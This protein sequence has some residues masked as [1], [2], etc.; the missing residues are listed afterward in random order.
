M[1]RR[2]LAVLALLILVL[3]ATSLFIGSGA[4][5]RTPS[6]AGPVIER[7]EVAAPERATEWPE[8]EVEALLRN[9][10]NW[11]AARLMREY[12]DTNPAAPPGAVLVAARAEAGWGGWD[13][14]RTL[15]E[16]REWLDREGGGEGWFW[17]ARAL[18]YDDQHETAAR[19]YDRYLGT[20]DADADPYRTTVVGL[21]QGFLL[22]RAGRMD[23]GTAALDG[24]RDFAPSVA[25]WID[26]LAAEALAG[27]GD[28]A[29]VR[30]RIDDLIPGALETRAKRALLQ[31][32]EEAGDIAGARA[33]ALDYRGAADSD[34]ARAAFSVTAAR[35]ALA[36]GDAAA[37]RADLR[38]VL[39]TAPGSRAAVDAA[40]MLT[41]LGALSTA[42][43]LAIAR[44]YDRHGNNRRAAEGYREWLASGSG[45]A[46]GRR[47]IRYA[48][49]RALFD[50][51][52]YAEAEEILRDLDGVPANRAATALYTAGRAQYRRGQRDAALRTFV[53][54]AERYPGSGAGAQALFLIA[55]LSHD[56]GELVRARDVYRRVVDDFPGHDR[57]GLA[58]MRLAGIEFLDADHAAAAR[59]WEDYRSRYPRGQ[60]WLK[61]TYWAGRAYEAMGD[62]E[63]ARI[64]YREAIEREPLS[65]Y[66]LRAAERLD[67]SFWPVPM[68]P[69]PEDD[70]A[71]R[72][73]IEEWLEGIDLLRDAG[74]YD[75]A[76]AEVDRWIDRV[77]GDPRLLYPLAEAL[78]QRGYTVSGIRLGHK[79]EGI[80]GHLNPRLLR[81]LYPFPYREMIEAEAREKGLDPFL[82]AALTRQESL[83]KARIVSPVGARGL[84]QIMP[85][86]GRQIAPG[87]GIEQWDAE[88][89]FNPEINVH[90]GTRYLADQMERY[91]AF[92][93]YV[94][95][96][97]NA[98]PSRVERWK[99]IYPEA[100]DFELFT[101]RIPY[102]ETRGYVKIL[103]RNKAI[104]E[105]LYGE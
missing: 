10:Q 82:V 61:A 35:I 28:T 43:R 70:A 12:L 92:L 57:M 76:E 47:E 49:G 87:V 36:M 91:D 103:T 77:G 78:T 64:R 67:Q 62:T 79:L 81:I 86:T 59:I 53:D 72:E 3:V 89:L 94:F 40:R 5:P 83:F 75:E 48:L 2:I 101:E 85:E 8:S 66:A 4:E 97:Y 21:R 50:I 80:E 73:R 26:L 6:A 100:G 37:V 38:T 52:E 56:A 69:L 15:L 14:V 60:R 104:Y 32:T 34:A 90:M 29:R 51:G 55:D 20:A 25:R 22:L 46:D 18:E 44:I 95:S 33:L 39:D 30:R 31:A 102:S 17:L 99:E 63:Q 54:V 71:A 42:D 98:G 9:G 88:L 84:M 13:R 24:A 16:G 93:P 58:M 74:L 27:R 105:G 11:R 68:G 45:S 1:S 19:A 7:V 41:D 23:E 65:Y 96:A